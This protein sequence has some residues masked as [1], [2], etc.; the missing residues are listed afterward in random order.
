MYL[1][2]RGAYTPTVPQ[3]FD[4]NILIDNL[5]ATL[6]NSN[7]SPMFAGNN[8]HAAASQLQGSSFTNN[9]SPFTVS[10]IPAPRANV[11]S[12]LAPA[13]S[14]LVTETTPCLPLYI[15]WQIR[16]PAGKFSHLLENAL[17]RVCPSH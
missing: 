3:Q 16:P 1:H 12:P 4:R 10:E 13:S 15:R 6:L 8:S 9:S 7:L 5:A 17:V 14:L 2:I 11:S